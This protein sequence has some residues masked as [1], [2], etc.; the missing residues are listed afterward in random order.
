[1]AK[2]LLWDEWEDRGNCHL[3]LFKGVFL[4]EHANGA[5]KSE[6]TGNALQNDFYGAFRVLEVIF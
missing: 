1:M 5:T 3:G 6:I 4:S 2:E